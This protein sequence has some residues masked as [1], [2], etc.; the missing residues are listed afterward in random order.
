[1]ASGLLYWMKQLFVSKTNFV[2]NGRSSCKETFPILP[3]IKF[4]IWTHWCSQKVFSRCMFLLRCYISLR[5]MDQNFE[6]GGTIGYGDSFS[7]FL[8]RHLIVF[9]L[10][11]ILNDAAQAVKAYSGRRP[12]YC[13][14]IGWGP[15]S[16]L[17]GHV[18]GLLFCF[19]V[20]HFCLPFSTLSK[21]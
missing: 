1:M 6:V 4:V 10:H 3:V 5:D 2:N 8:I 15:N 9:R 16:C 17:L 19:Y 11:A 12:C 14:M 20:K 13:Y 21:F 18:I 7:E